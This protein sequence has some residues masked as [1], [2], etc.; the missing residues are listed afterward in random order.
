MPFLSQAQAH[1][2]Y[3][4]HPDIAARWQKEFHQNIKSLPKHVKKMAK[5]KKKKSK[6][7]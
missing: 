5:K 7:Y 4:Q 2:L 1:F 3:S 6:G